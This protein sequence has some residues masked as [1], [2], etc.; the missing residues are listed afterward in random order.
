MATK[1]VRRGVAWRVAGAAVLGAALSACGGGGGGDDGSASDAVVAP[2]SAAATLANSADGAIGGVR[3]AVDAAQRAASADGSLIGAGLFLGG[4]TAQGGAGIR[5]AGGVR[6]KASESASCYEIFETT[7]CAGRVSITT[8]F[9]LDVED[10]PAGSTATLRF[11]GI[12]TVWDGAT[13]ELDGQMRFVF[14]TTLEG[15]EY[16]W[17]QESLVI[18]LVDF[19]GSYGG[20]AFGPVDVAARIEIDAR[21]GTMATTIDGIRFSDLQVE[22]TATGS[23]LNGGTVRLAAPAQPGVYVEVALSNWQIADGRP[24]AG[25]ATV[26]GSGPIRHLVNVQDT[27]ADRVVYSVVVD[28]GGV[29]LAAY[30]V[31][32]TYAN[33]T[34]SYSIAPN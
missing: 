3:A 24:T 34:A 31:V 29:P 5:S 12:G 33:G 6:A 11:D 27:S 7:P 30:T 4:P 20:I 32:A 21:A 9:D 19:S 28:Q 16:R 26:S 10:I 2:P 22:P 14:E 1:R 18:Q 15:D 25:S 23:L 13:V 8:S 17:R